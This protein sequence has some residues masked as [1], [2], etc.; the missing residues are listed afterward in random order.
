LLLEMADRQPEALAAWK[1]VRTKGKQNPVA[2]ER[3]TA[4]VARLTSRK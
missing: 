4:G 2:Y 1:N 3:A